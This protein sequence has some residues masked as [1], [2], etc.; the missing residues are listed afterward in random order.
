MTQQAATLVGTS[1]VSYGAVSPTPSSLLKSKD[2]QLAI[3]TRVDIHL[4]TP[5]LG[6]AS[7]QFSD[8]SGGAV[9]LPSAGSNPRSQGTADSSSKGKGKG[10]GK[11]EYGWLKTAVTLDR[12]RSV[13]W[14]D[15]VDDYDLN[16]PGMVEN[17]WRSAAWSP[18][19]LS[20]Q[21]GSCVL[22]AITTNGEALVFGAAK[23]ATT[24]EWTEIADLTSDMVRQLAPDQTSE[25]VQTPTMRRE[26][27][28]A[29]LRCQTTAIAWSTA[30]PGTADDKSLLALGHRSGEVSIWRFGTDWKAQCVARVAPAEEVNILHAL[31]WSEWTVSGSDGDAD[32]TATATA[33]LAIADGEGRVFSLP[34]TQ[35]LRRSRAEPA[36]AEGGEDGEEIVVVSGKAVS[37]GEANGRA[38]TQLCWV[39]KSDGNEMQRLLRLAYSK[40][41]TVSLATLEPDPNPAADG[42]TVWKFAREVEEVELPMVGEE[43][44]MGATPWALC[45]GLA[46]LPHQDS[47]LV[48]LSSSAFYHLRLSPHLR[49]TSPDPSPSA[50]S[51]S[52]ED[53]AA[54]S[55]AALTSAARDIFEEVLGRVTGLKKD[56]FQTTAV[57]LGGKMGRKEGAKV[58][59]MVLLN[60]GAGAT[61]EGAEKGVGRIGDVAF[62]FE[63]ARPDASIYRP[64]GQMKTYL[65]VADLTGTALDETTAL[66]ECMQVLARP[67]NPRTL[68]PLGKLLTPLHSVR[69]FSDSTPFVEG[70][71]QYLRLPSVPAGGQ[72][73]DTVMSV[74]DAG[75][76]EKM[77]EKIWADEML[78]QI[79]EKETLARA[80]LREETLVDELRHEV[81]LAHTDLIRLLAKEILGRL[82]SV[83]SSLE[84]SDATKAI[85]A[86]LLLASASTLPPTADD[87][88]SATLP[89]EAL[90]RAFEQPDVHCPAC[91]A[92]VPLAN[93]RY[94]CCDSGHQWERCSVTL[95]LVATV[96][97]RTCTACERKALLKS[98]DTVVHELLR[99]ASCCLFCGGRWMR[100]R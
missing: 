2:G 80:M 85:Y 69:C 87:P 51:P 88:Q 1:T 32:E 72:A 96:Q 14:S 24:G 11:E 16:M 93:T 62:I 91:R 30:V 64:Y 3:V 95:D 92:P 12:K 37:V 71:L 9:P 35:N 17:H 54:L 20:A 78:E 79:R 73:T 60:E 81:Q 75:M 33:H 70:M 19:G 59:G 86:R 18:A 77:E 65:A 39:T 66:E 89:P 47:L 21:L 50:V 67:S 38:A 49:L 48:S 90:S 42:G 25:K 5:S 58:V 57:K 52:N 43:R 97:V 10:K 84:L 7:K 53:P 26:L 99:N 34:V 8:T 27:V 4:L 22:A 36:A 61:S 55:P 83:L 31:S 13:R 23:N 45:S 74:A 29:L 63:T 100:V 94:A 40:L 68:C 56:R 46:C 28:A 82:A 41:G 15:W 76:R 44:W 6:Y 98:S